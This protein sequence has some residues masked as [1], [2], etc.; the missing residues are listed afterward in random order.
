M[1]DSSWSR[2]TATSIS[3]PEPTLAG[4]PR[5]RAANHGVECTASRVRQSTLR[6]AQRIAIHTPQSTRSSASSGFTLLEAVVALTIFSAGALTLYGLFN[7]NLVALQRV[8]DVTAHLP[9]A[10]RAVTLLSVINPRQR[11]KGQVEFDD[12]TVVW[13]ARLLEPVRQGQNAYGY[14]GDYEIGLYRIEFTLHAR[15]RPVGTYRLRLIGYE[16]VRGDAPSSD[17]DEGPLF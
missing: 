17:E 7:T 14:M 13:S 9:A 5:T 15:G 1:S 16:K 10:H 3:T 6:Q 2:P 8:R 12:Y 4:S 11:E